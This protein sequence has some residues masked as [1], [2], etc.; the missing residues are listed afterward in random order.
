MHYNHCITYLLFAGLMLNAC[1]STETNSD[2]YQ[3]QGDPVSLYASNAKT[4]TLTSDTEKDDASNSNTNWNDE[5]IDVDL[6]R[7]DGPC[8]IRP[9]KVHRGGSMDPEGCE[10]FLWHL[11]DE[12]QKFRTTAWLY[13]C[14]DGCKHYPHNP[15]NQSL[16]VLTDQTAKEAFEASQFMLSA[17]EDV[18]Y[19]TDIK[20]SLF[21][22]MSYI[23][24]YV[25]KAIS[26]SDSKPE[27]GTVGTRESPV[28][29]RAQYHIPSGKTTATG[30]REVFGSFTTDDKD[31]RS[32]GVVRCL[33]VASDKDGYPYAFDAI[34]VPQDFGAGQVLFAIQMDGRRYTLKLSS[35][36][37]KPFSLQP[38]L[39]YTAYLK[40]KNG[41]LV[42]VNPPAEWKDGNN[43]LIDHI[44][45]TL[46]QNEL[47]Q[48]D[49]SAIDALSW[50]KDE[51]KTDD[52]AIG[53][54]RWQLDRLQSDDSRQKGSEWTQDDSQ[55][56]T[57]SMGTSSAWQEE[58]DE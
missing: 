22:Q 20:Y 1:S 13:R 38:G 34:V 47:S 23:T 55:T 39:H 7:T 44:L 43:D 19:H 33:Q 17:P 30:S 36:L 50:R 12:G 41:I 3:P 8:D 26:S 53:S 51:S 46:W 54:L 32:R 52:S 28:W 45:I 31:P 49:G 10:P 21:H 14:L 48:Q 37:T 40:A 24:F 5:I 15:D 16:G 56:D 58:T 35:K 4:G 42:A 27:S 29:V 2:D 6:H 11:R 9:F 25:A 18:D 57:T